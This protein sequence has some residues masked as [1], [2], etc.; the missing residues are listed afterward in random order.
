MIWGGLAI[1]FVLGTIH[2][3]AQCK[4]WQRWESR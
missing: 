3:W 1:G 4:A 2:G